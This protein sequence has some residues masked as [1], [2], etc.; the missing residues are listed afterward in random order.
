MFDDKGE[1]YD[2]VNFRTEE[3]S[4]I[5]FPYTPCLMLL[6]REVQYSSEVAPYVMATAKDFRGSP[7]IPLTGFG[8]GATEIGTS[9]YNLELQSLSLP[10]VDIHKCR[11]IY[12]TITHY[13]QERNKHLFL[14]LGYTD[15]LTRMN[16]DDVGGPIVHATEYKLM[17]LLGYEPAVEDGK[18]ID[19]TRFAVP[20]AGISLG[21]D[22]LRRSVLEWMTKL[23]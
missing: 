15:R 4:R 12:D 3:T 9:G 6:S 21:N 2:V 23:S 16:I 8:Y 5:Y 10:F 11:S 19:P 20:T 1:I 18:V 17:G 14:C 22:F 7:N 13:D